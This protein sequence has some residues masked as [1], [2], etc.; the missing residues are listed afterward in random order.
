VLSAVSNEINC[1]FFHLLENPRMCDRSAVE[2]VA[3]DSDSTENGGS[4]SP[5]NHAIGK[6]E[7][8]PAHTECKESRR[9]LTSQ[10]VDSIGHKRY[11]SLGERL[12]FE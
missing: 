12:F 11:M 7:Y 3:S 4:M 10:K 1:V 9:R 6:R 2:A 5:V 8:G